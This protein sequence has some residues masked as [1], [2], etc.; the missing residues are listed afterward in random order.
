LI[1]IED[2]GETDSGRIANEPWPVRR[3]LYESA[4]E[5][6]AKLHCLPTIA[7]DGIRSDLPAEFDAPLYQWE[8]HYF[9]ENCLGRYFALDQD[10]SA[11][12]VA[13]A[14]FH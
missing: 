14:G 10:A 4:L 11:R 2:S 9:F 5:Q 7:A 1:W 6:I 13:A 12:A 3:D 8:Q